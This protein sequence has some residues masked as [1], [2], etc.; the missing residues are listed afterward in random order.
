MKCSAMN[1]SSSPQ[2]ER[3]KSEDKNIAAMGVLENELDTI[4]NLIKGGA[5]TGRISNALIRVPLAN[6]RKPVP[7]LVVYV[8]DVLT[9]ER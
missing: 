1:M 5:E 7:R 4:Q 9:G 8:S 6:A 2:E 3:I